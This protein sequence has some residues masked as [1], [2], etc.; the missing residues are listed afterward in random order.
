[1]QRCEAGA[2]VNL[3]DLTI[4]G[5]GHETQGYS[6]RDGCGSTICIESNWEVQVWSGA[7][8][9]GSKAK[10]QEWEE[11]YAEQPAVDE[12]DCH[13]AL[14]AGHLQGRWLAPASEPAWNAV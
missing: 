10:A 3:S 13:R 8:S 9:A 11:E 14:T 4:Q 12:G 2:K 6:I 1:M 7:Q 5:G